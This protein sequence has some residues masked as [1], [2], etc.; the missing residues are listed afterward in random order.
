LVLLVHRV[1]FT[2]TMGDVTTAE[3]VACSWG[4]GQTWRARVPEAAGRIERVILTTDRRGEVVG[5]GSVAVTREWVH[6][7][8][9]ATESEIKCSAFVP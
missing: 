9:K 3:A 6:P 7:R 4:D 1:A 2:V 8:R 5:T